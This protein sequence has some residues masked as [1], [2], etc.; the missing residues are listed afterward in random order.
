L[1]NLAVPRRLSKDPQLELVELPEAHERDW[2][3]RC[4]FEGVGDD[5]AERE[6]FQVWRGSSASP[7]AV[8]ARRTISDT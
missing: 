3:R 6:V 1:K 8:A 7:G 2:R 4:A 5:V